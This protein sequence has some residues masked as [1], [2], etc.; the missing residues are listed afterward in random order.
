MRYCKSIMRLWWTDTYLMWYLMWYWRGNDCPPV[1]TQITVKLLTARNLSHRA[2]GLVI[3][4]FKC[5]V[6]VG[7]CY[8][9]KKYDYFLSIILKT[10]ARGIK[11][12]AS[13]RNGKVMGLM[14]GRCKPGNWCSA[15]Y[16]DAQTRLRRFD[17]RPKSCH[18]WRHEKLLLMLLCRMRV[19]NSTGKGSAMDLNRHNSLPCNRL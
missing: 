16:I 18:N 7:N 3:S 14:L 6:N 8:N 15:L 2:Y 5:S 9:Y 19:I 1:Q 10:R 11:C 13:A 4:I 17:V 12:S